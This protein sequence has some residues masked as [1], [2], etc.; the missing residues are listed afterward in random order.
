MG[1]EA[2]LR[3][4]EAVFN[5]A[6]ALRTKSADPNRRTVIAIAGPPASGKSSLA[7]ALMAKFATLDAK[8]TPAAGLLAMDGY[9][10]DNDILRRRGLLERKGAPP[11]FNAADFTQAVRDVGIMGRNAILPRFDRQRDISIAHASEIVAEA[12]YVVVEGNYLLLKEPPWDALNT[13][14][15]LRVFISPPR[16][17]LLERLCQRWLDHGL[18][19]Q[20]AMARAKGNDLV[21]ADLVLDNSFAADIVLGDE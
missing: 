2:L 16:E 21:N 15:D 11:T 1:N 13:M 4:A 5:R 12:A 19:A 10:L 6:V 17:V 9:H 7:E 14:F 18:D 3:D 8:G 20:A